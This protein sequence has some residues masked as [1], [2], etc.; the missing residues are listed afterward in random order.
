MSGVDQLAD[1]NF[2][3][4]HDININMNC[5]FDAWYFGTDANTPAGLID[6]VTV[7]LHEIGHGIGFIGSMNAGNGS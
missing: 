6:F 4:E 1:N 5:G 7:V 3:E 2:G